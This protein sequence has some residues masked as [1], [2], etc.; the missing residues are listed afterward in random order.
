MFS[1]NTG[2]AA[3]ENFMS[4]L[5]ISTEA[6]NEKYLGLHVYIGGSKRKTCEYLK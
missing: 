5:D 4:I 6:R 1:R 2:N 3:R